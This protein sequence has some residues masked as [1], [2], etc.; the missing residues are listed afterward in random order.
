MTKT[1]RIT[2]IVSALIL[3]LTVINNTWYFLC[4]AQVSILQ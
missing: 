4:I 1:E 2:S 3:L